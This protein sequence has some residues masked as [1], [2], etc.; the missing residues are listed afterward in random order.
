MVIP[1]A[2]KILTNDEMSYNLCKF[3]TYS[4]LLFSP[5]YFMITGLKDDI[6]EFGTNAHISAILTAAE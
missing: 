1:I 2:N 4:L 6:I 5:L 3:F